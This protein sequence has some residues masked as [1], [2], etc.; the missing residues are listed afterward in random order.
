MVRFPTRIERRTWGGLSAYLDLDDALG[1]IALLEIFCLC[2]ESCFDELLESRVEVVA[3]LERD[4][5]QALS[6]EHERT[7][8]QSGTA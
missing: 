8:R 7:W 5:D 2:L 4:A 6:V 3:L 1:R